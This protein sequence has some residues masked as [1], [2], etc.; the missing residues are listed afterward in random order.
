VNTEFQ[1]LAEHFVKLLEV[2]LVL[3]NLAEEIHALLDNVLAD[4]FE[5]LVLLEG[6]TG[7]VEREILGVD[8]A[9][10]EVEVFGD[11]ILAVVH[12]EDATNVELDVVALL[13]GLEE[14]EGRT[15]YT[16]SVDGKRYLKKVR[17]YRLGMKRMA[18]NSS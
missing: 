16:V 7:D 1:V 6:S 17:P 3:G 8:D 12:D 10:N 15:K 13:L 11:D 9:L 2:V 5:D 4:N 18:L 14:V